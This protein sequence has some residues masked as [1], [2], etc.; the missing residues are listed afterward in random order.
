[1]CLGAS[2]V[3]YVSRAVDDLDKLGRCIGYQSGT[4][5][6]AHAIGHAGQGALH[7]G[8]LLPRGRGRQHSPGRSLLLLVRCE[9]SEIILGARF[10]GKRATLGAPDRK[11]TESPF[12][13][14]FGVESSIGGLTGE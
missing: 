2:V 12:E 6:R 8:R 9:R 10:A 1:M 5:A 4:T 14:T 7:D 3:S 13:G 11:G